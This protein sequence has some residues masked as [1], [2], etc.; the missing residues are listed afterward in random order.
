MLVTI[1]RL[2]ERQLPN[3]EP[4]GNGKVGFT[5]NLYI[6]SSTWSLKPCCSG[7]RPDVT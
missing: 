7:V 5:P 4:M 2:W 3:Q 6:F 1:M